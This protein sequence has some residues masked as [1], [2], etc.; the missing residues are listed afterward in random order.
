MFAEANR[1]EKTTQP[2]IQGTPC[3]LPPAVKRSGREV[4]H[5]ALPK[6]VKNE[7]S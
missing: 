3:V 5:S 1:S 6:E 2:S 4:Y 7:F